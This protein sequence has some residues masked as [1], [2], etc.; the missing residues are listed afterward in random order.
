MVTTTTITVLAFLL[1][2][3]SGV[4]KA[5]QDKVNFHFSESIFAKLNGYFWNPVY[6]SLNK[7]KDGIK[8][9][10]EK[11]FG[12]STFLVGVTDAWHLFQ[13][14]RD[15]TFAIA[16]FLLGACSTWWSALIGYALSRI[17]FQVFFKKIFTKNKSE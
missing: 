8:K 17:I 1:L 13:T 12:S 7:W 11:F 6:S 2:I 16:F 3:I 14:I 4:S 9:R 5:V 10:G 15:T